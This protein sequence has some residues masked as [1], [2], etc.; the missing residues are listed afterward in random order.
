MAA[1]LTGMGRSVFVENIFESRFRHVPELRRMGADILT[2]G[3]TAVVSGVE[4]LTASHVTAT[5]LRGG[6]AMVIAGLSARGT[7]VVSDPGHILRGYDGLDEV[8][9]SLGGDVKIT[10]ERV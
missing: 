9:C 4:A 10:K 1:S 7:T 6:A 3:R 5:D 8:L 2:D